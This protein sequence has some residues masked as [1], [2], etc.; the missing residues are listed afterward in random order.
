[1][2]LLTCYLFIGTPYFHSLTLSLQISLRQSELK[3]FHS[4]CFVSCMNNCCFASVFFFMQKYFLY[5]R[6]CFFMGTFSSVFLYQ[7]WGPIFFFNLNHHKCLSQLFLLHLNRLD[8]KLTIICQFRLFI[9][10]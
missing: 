10:I 2:F 1:M 8:L 5:H 4:F 7:P 9:P 6:D 3:T